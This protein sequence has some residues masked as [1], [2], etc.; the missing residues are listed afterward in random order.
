MSDKA[1]QTPWYHS[2]VSSVVVAIVVGMA[3]SFLTAQVTLARFDERL[4]AVES[5]QE[6]QKL[7]SLDASRDRRD[8]SNQ[9]ARMEGKL[10][11]LLEKRNDN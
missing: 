9:L 6:A 11:Y 5:T 8:L 7:Q 3:S 10:D 2:V 1:E 4:M